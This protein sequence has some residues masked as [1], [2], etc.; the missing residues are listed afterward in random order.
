ME[1]DENVH[2][3]VIN[4]TLVFYLTIQWVIFVRNGTTHNAQLFFP[5]YQVKQ[6][7]C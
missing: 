7:E 1:V 5:L 2:D 3:L 6:I 4:T